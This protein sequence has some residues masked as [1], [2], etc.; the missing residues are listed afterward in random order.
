MYPRDLFFSKVS[1]TGLISN[2]LVCFCRCLL[3]VYVDMYWSLL[4]GRGMLA[5]IAHHVLN[6]DD[7]GL[8]CRSLFKF[9]CVSMCSSLVEGL[10]LHLWVAVDTVRD[11]ICITF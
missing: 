10:F 5:Q 7:T 3:L 8:F 1:F 2:K 6:P 9:V 4:T 11:R